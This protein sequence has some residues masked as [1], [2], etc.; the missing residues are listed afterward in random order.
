MVESNG[1]G[2]RHMPLVGTFEDMPEIGVK[3]PRLFRA[4]IL[5]RTDKSKIGT[6][7]EWGRSLPPASK[8]IQADVLTQRVK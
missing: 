7:E 2:D 3:P 4:P 5:K 6:E 8:N 1:G